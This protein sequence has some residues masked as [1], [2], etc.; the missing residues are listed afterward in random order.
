MM[1]N[2]TQAFLGRT[3]PQLNLFSV[4]F[5]VSI[6]LAFLVIFMILPDLQIVL[7]RSLENPLQLIR[8]GL[9][10]PVAR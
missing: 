1:F 8:Q 6:P 7:V 5:A 3:S 10:V 9:E 2:L 4:G